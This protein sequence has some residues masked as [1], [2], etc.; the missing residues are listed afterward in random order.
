MTQVEI[1]TNLMKQFGD[2]VPIKRIAMYAEAEYLI[3]YEVAVQL[4]YELA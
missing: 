1:I 3:P 2:R 4:I